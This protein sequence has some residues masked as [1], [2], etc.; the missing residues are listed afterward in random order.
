MY[1]RNN[2]KGGT[3]KQN[4]KPYSLFLVGALL[5]SV[6]GSFAFAEEAEPEEIDILTE[7]SSAVCGDGFIKGDEQCDDGNTLDEPA[8]PSECSPVCGA[9]F[10]NDVFLSEDMLCEGNA[11]VLGADN[12]TI[13]CDGKIINGSGQGVGIQ[14]E[15]HSGITI[16]NCVIQ[17]FQIG[18]KIKDS[19]GNTIE[20][21]TITKNG[22]S[23]PNLSGIHFENVNSSVIDSN[24]ISYNDLGVFLGHS[25][26]NQ[27]TGNQVLNNEGD[28]IHLFFSENND[29]VGGTIGN[30]NQ[31]SFS[32]ALLESLEDIVEPSVLS[33]NNSGI[34]LYA[35]GGNLVS[36]VYLHDNEHTAI[37]IYQSEYVIIDRNNIDENCGGYA[38]LLAQHSDNLTIT[39]NNVTRGTGYG[40]VINSSSG[41]LIQENNITDN[42]NNGI[43]ISGGGD[44]SFHKIIGN[45]IGDNRGSG[46]QLS[47]EYDCLIE[48]NNIFGNSYNGISLLSSDLIT[49]K[50]NNVYENCK[51]IL[52]DTST[53]IISDT[54]FENNFCEEIYKTGL[55][56]IEDS[57][58]EL[59]NSDFIGNGEFGILAGDESLLIESSEIQQLES[60][61]RVLE[62]RLR[63]DVL[64][65][66]NDVYIEN[67]AIIPLGGTL[68]AQDCPILVNGHEFKLEGSEGQQGFVEFLISSVL[69]LGSSSVYGGPNYA[70]EFEFFDYLIPKEVKTETYSYNTLIVH[71]FN[72]NPVSSSNYRKEAFGKWVKTERDGYLFASGE[73]SSAGAYIMKIFYADNE[74]ADS[75][76]KENSLF[77]QFFDEETGKWVSYGSSKG[78]VNTEENYVWAEVEEGKYGVFGIFGDKVSSSPAGAARGGFYECFTDWVC[79]EWSECVDGFETREC[80]KENE[81]CMLRSD[82]K[83][84]EIRECEVEEAPEEDEELADD[85]STPA[86]TT[87]PVTEGTGVV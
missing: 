5:L 11:L 13:D 60:S 80:V 75:K 51:G 83:P 33:Y 35:S 36:G 46:I 62:W 81:R 55:H 18:V 64:C 42:T 1:C 20:N 22:L 24:V 16:R 12:I 73:P 10:K 47:S 84:E 78:G 61:G 57:V 45:E 7:M 87:Q 56:V 69:P 41:A 48:G 43:Y 58:V 85:A 52:V 9:T 28:G 54:G 79:T 70:I 38:G 14:A 8:G 29:I 31:G 76:L 3:L 72:K 39:N 34:F 30:N 27:L 50:E 49:V 53:A 32:F 19:M 86:G 6:L 25:N 82:D 26:S 37:S 67:G 2:I 21:N 71:F 44:D 15:G 59:T 65:E 66:D 68:T 63:E 23:T 74:L 17:Q 4:K 40:I 77:I